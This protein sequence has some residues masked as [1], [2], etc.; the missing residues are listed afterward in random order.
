MI[1]VDVPRL[2]AA[3]AIPFR[4]RGRELQ[5]RCPAHADR[6]PSWSINIATGRH[7]CFSCSWGG[8]AVGL[9]QQVLHVEH[10]DAVAWMLEHG[11][12]SEPG[13]PAGLLVQPVT[14]A[15]GRIKHDLFALPPGVMQRSL[16]S[17][18]ATARRYAESR[19]LDERACARWSIGY[20]VFGRLAG[21]I[22]FPVID[23]DGVLRSYQA[24]TFDGRRPRYLTPAPREHADHT[25][26]FG[27]QHWR[28]G[29]WCALTE[30]A[31]NA[32]ACDQA[33]AWNVAALGGSDVTAE[34]LLPLLQFKTIVLVTDPDAA[35]DSAASKA[36]AGLAR[37]CRVVRA[38]LPAGSDARSISTEQ[39]GAL[40]TLALR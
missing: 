35:G 38:A 4:K 30:G 8:G 5:A 18:P 27:Q 21:R 19:G 3:L 13:L 11:C 36:A 6:N 22:V 23:R 37:K 29:D 1:Q 32:I 14:A 33:G 31:L 9:A 28:I 40:L 25:V 10:Q 39:L 24:R 34:H 7:H 15:T 20:A 12:A 2:L 16:S 26:L 17:W